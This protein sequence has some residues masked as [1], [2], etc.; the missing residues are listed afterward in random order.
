MGI[1]QK[2]ESGRQQVRESVTDFFI[3]S[4][5]HPDTWTIFA[6]ALPYTKY[7]W[8]MRR[9]MRWISQKA[10]GDTDITRDFEY[11]NWDDVRDFALKISDSLTIGS[12][13]H[14]GPSRSEIAYS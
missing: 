10:G 13:R 9:V 3:G 8:F 1:C 6:G 2:E 12:P 14:G 5:W 11:A 7:N 4:G